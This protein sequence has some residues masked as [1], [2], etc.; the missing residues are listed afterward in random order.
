MVF[1]VSVILL[2]FLMAYLLLIAAVPAWIVLGIIKLIKRKNPSK[3]LNK[4]FKIVSFILLIDIP[5]W[6]FLLVL[7][8]STMTLM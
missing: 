3:G 1:M 6:I 7:A 4:A 2:V 5:I 8:S